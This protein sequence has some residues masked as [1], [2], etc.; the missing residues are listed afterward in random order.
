MFQTV[1]I[2]IWECNCHCFNVLNVKPYT[3]VWPTRGLK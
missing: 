2:I 3:A 1:N